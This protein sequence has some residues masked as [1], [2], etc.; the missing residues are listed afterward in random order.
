MSDVHPRD[1]WRKA[2]FPQPVPAD[3]APADPVPMDEPAPVVDA[4]PET[5]PP[6][7]EPAIDVPAPVDVPVPEA[8]PADPVDIA[9][10]GMPDAP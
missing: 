3:V 1:D 9:L 4:P 10:Q 7:A 5:V 8:A 2:Y 6:A